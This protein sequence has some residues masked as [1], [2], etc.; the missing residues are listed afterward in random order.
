MKKV[1]IS[2]SK[3]PDQG[4]AER[5]VLQ[6][7]AD[8]VCAEWDGDEE[9]G[10]AP[11][12]GWPSWTEEK[13]RDADY[14]LC[15]CTTAYCESFEQPGGNDR[16]DRG[17][18]REARPIVER[19]R[20]PKSARVFAVQYGGACEH[21]IPSALR[22]CAR[23]VVSA[24]SALPEQEQYQRLLAVLRRPKL[25]VFRAEPI[26]ESMRRALAAKFLCVRKRLGREFYPDLHAQQPDIVHLE[27]GDGD[28]QSQIDL[29]EL[30]WAMG[31]VAKLPLLVLSMAPWRDARAFFEARV[32]CLIHPTGA[33]SLQVVRRYTDE[34]YKRL[35]AGAT[36]FEAHSGAL[37]SVSSQD[38]FG[39]T[40]ETYARATRFVG[41]GPR[42]PRTSTPVVPTSPGLRATVDRGSAADDASHSREPP[43]AG[44]DDDDDDDGAGGV[45]PEGADSVPP[46]DEPAEPPDSATGPDDDDAP[47]TSGGDVLPPGSRWNGRR[48]V[49]RTYWLAHIRA[50]DP[51]D[52]AKVHDVG[53]QVFR[54][55]PLARRLGLAGLCVVKPTGVI[56][57]VEPRD[58]DE[59]GAVERLLADVRRFTD[60]L[61][62]S[63]EQGRAPVPI[64]IGLARGQCTQ[65]PTPVLQQDVVGRGVVDVTRASEASCRLR[66]DDQPIVWA[67]PCAVLDPERANELA[68]LG[69][70]LR[71]EEDVWRIEG[72]PLERFGWQPRTFATLPGERNLPATPRQRPSAFAISAA[73]A[74]DD[75]GS[76]PEHMSRVRRCL[77]EHLPA[78]ARAWSG[79]RADSQPLVLSRLLFFEHTGNGFRLALYLDG[80]EDRALALVDWLL[81]LA[82]EVEGWDI[83]L[84]MAATCGLQPRVSL[85]RWSAPMPA[86][87]RQDPVSWC[88]QTVRNMRSAGAAGGLVVAT[89]L[90]ELLPASVNWSDCVLGGASARELIDVKRLVSAIDAKRSTDRAVAVSFAGG[91]ALEWLKRGQQ[92]K[93]LRSPALERGLRQAGNL[94]ATRAWVEAVLTMTAAIALSRPGVSVGRAVAALALAA[95]GGIL[96]GL[97]G[98][99]FYQRYVFIRL[100]PTLPRYHFHP[101][102]NAGARESL[103][104]S[105]LRLRFGLAARSRLDRWKSVWRECGVWG[106]LFWYDHIA[107]APR[108]ERARIRALK[109][110]PDAERKNV[111]LF[112]LVAGTI[113]YGLGAWATVHW[114]LLSFRGY[115]GQAF[116]TLD[117]GSPTWNGV[118]R[119][120]W[121]ETGIPVGL[122][123]LVGLLW[124]LCAFW[125]ARKI[126]FY[127]LHMR[128]RRYDLIL[129]EEYAGTRSPEIES[130]AEHG[131]WLDFVNGFVHLAILALI[132][133]GA[134]A[135]GSWFGPIVAAGGFGLSVASGTLSM[136]HLRDARRSAK[137]WGRSFARG[138]LRHDGKDLFS[139]ASTDQDTK[140]DEILPLDPMHAAMHVMVSR[141]D[142][143]MDAL[144]QSSLRGADARLDGGGLV[145]ASLPGNVLCLAGAA[146]GS[147]GWGPAHVPAT[148]DALYADG[149][150]AAKVVHSWARYADNMTLD[151]E[152]LAAGPI[153]GG[154]LTIRPYELRLMTIDPDT[155]GGGFLGVVA[156]AGKNERLR[157]AA[158]CER[159]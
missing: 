104:R 6:L 1:F 51:V 123:S 91:P 128:M 136:Q 53:A 44:P 66:A 31:A 71:V 134:G 139:T 129:G 22:G 81:T 78:L 54:G 125:R 132:A 106:L 149:T 84:I 119:S 8:N 109:S 20:D 143:L 15:I 25:L 73:L 87:D 108:N 126:P 27:T 99:R 133:W 82:T 60:A 52:L 69:F 150:F 96:F 146:F 35:A 105:A 30:G 70:V 7:K 92:S 36:I 32:R 90:L 145:V 156:R 85:G 77:R 140:R 152:L 57:G 61:C 37:Q 14:V 147:L 89:R 148:V 79:D 142:I 115:G 68:A 65:W 10:G 17:V 50:V 74:T 46:D 72:G 144:C 2:Y 112:V 40:N 94:L 103:I 45:V 120:A 76:L 118:G 117:Q 21:D 5:L 102:R 55:E 88:D 116:L 18:T 67:M 39:L 93:V 151:F 12:E 29:E 141:G 3:V 56:L 158:Y 63:A 95:A 111:A 113:L 47:C 9:D 80:H 101:E 75:A 159:T 114:D 4:F 130:S 124:N 83:P 24:D 43:A 23:Y 33:P 28:R 97:L 127:V 34:L 41:G 155:L 49:T 107:R 62:D 26:P 100:I 16:G 58:G 154:R 135:R 48:W 38:A 110:L 122:A 121:L 11:P 86:P 98:R 59:G 13:I 138:W 64:A 131:R 19:V 137:Q 153:E 42:S 157:V